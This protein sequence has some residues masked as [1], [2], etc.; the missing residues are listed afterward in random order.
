M[1]QKP[2]ASFIH[3]FS[4]PPSL[5]LRGGFSVKPAGFFL[6]GWDEAGLPLI[7]FF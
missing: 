1:K 5:R 6:V 7:L 4:P 2:E 3:P